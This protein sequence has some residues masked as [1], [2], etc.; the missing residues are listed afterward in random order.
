MNTDEEIMLHTQNWVK[1]FIVQHNVCPFASREVEKNSIRQCV[2]RS[3]KTQVALE[4]LMTECVCLDDNADT[5][6][7]LI[8]F[9]TL[10]RNFYDYLDFV[11]LAEA[12]LADQG[13]DGVYQIAT[14]H[15]DYIFDGTMEDDVTNYTNRS[16]YPMLHLLRESSLDKAIAFHGNTEQ[17]P[18]ENILKMQELGKQSIEKILQACF[19]NH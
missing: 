8:I 17:I 2:I 16:P 5:E 10:F 7:T 19:T 9:P 1:S 15:P 3:K 14:F 4:E 12:C 13:Y 11:E 6:T 18:E